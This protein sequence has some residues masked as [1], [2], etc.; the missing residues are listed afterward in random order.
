MTDKRRRWHGRSCAIN[1]SRPVTALWHAIVQNA[2]PRY[3][4][5]TGTVGAN[6]WF[7]VDIA[8][9]RGNWQALVLFYAV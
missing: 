5:I 6:G 4:T 9:P 3:A 2:V 7:D 8:G 1:A